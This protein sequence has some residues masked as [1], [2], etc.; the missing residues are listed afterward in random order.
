MG[1]LEQRN[2][3]AREHAN[4]GDVTEMVNVPHPPEVRS[5]PISTPFK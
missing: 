1:Q 4:Q 2:S 3:H 5:M